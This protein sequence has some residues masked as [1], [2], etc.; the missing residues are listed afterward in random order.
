MRL[1]GR[2]VLLVGE[3]H[4][5]AQTSSYLL[6]R[7]GF[8]CHFAAN[9]QAASRLLNSHP[10]DL[11]LSTTQLSDGTGV[12]FLAAL[13]GL[14]VTAFLCLPVENGCYWLPALDAGKNCLGLSALRSSEFARALE[15]M[16][17]GLSHPGVGQA[18]GPKDRYA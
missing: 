5:R 1:S 12:G 6:R 16:T 7:W 14:P 17:R 9:V 13:S 10:I 4:R 2:D 3:I 18:D 8:R 15:E 11:V